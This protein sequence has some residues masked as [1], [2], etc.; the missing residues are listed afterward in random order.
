MVR[1]AWRWQIVVPLAKQ[2]MRHAKTYRVPI[3]G[4]QQQQWQQQWPQQQWAAHGQPAH[5]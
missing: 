3:A 4:Q 5:G 2:S 1:L